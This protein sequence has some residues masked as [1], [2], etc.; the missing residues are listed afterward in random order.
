MLLC[1][2]ACT[3]AEQFVAGQAGQQMSLEAS[4]QSFLPQPG[5][6]TQV[7]DMA[8]DGALSILW[9]V[10]DSIGVFGIPDAN[11][12]FV[13]TAGEAGM[14]ATFTGPTVSSPGYAYYP[15]S[16]AATSRTAIPVSIPS[17]QVYDGVQ[18]IARNDIKA[19][20]VVRSGDT[21]TLNF[22]QMAALVRFEFDLTGVSTLAADELLQDVTIHQTETSV[23][24]AGEFTYDLTNLEA[25]LTPGDYQMDGITLTFADPLPVSQKVVAYAV[26]APGQHAGNEWSCVFATDKHIVTFTTTALCDFEAGKYYTVPLTFEVLQNNDATYEEIPEVDPEEETANCYIV[27]EPGTYSFNATVIGNGE[28]GIIKGAGFH[29]EDPYINPQSA[30]VLWSDRKDFVTDVQLR[31]GRVYYTIPE[32]I[33]SSF[34]GTI[35]GNAVIAVYSEPNCQGDILWSWHIWGTK[36]EP[37][38]ETYTNQAGATFQVMDRDL[39]VSEVGRTDDVM[40]YQWGRKDPFPCQDIQVRSFYLDGTTLE[41]MSNLKGYNYR[42][43]TDVATIADAVKNPMYL[44]GGTKATVWPW[45]AEPNLYLWG[46]ANRV[47]PETLTDIATAGAGWNQ[48]KTIYDPSPVGYRVAN[49]FTF[50]GF[51]DMPSGTTGDVEDA[52]NGFNIALQR[53]D[54]INFVEDNTDEPSNEWAFMRYPGD[55]QGSIYPALNPIDGFD[56]KEESNVSA[57]YWWSAEAYIDATDNRARACYLET[58]DYKTSAGSSNKTGNTIDTY[59]RTGLLR[60][61]CPVRCVRE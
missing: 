1:A 5:T 34:D 13:N 24:M 20:E 36:G 39:G 31:N 12:P 53:L 16:A 33:A 32:A 59:A 17:E 21:Y 8:G 46:D 37:Q 56:G 43:T 58:D 28:E 4:S 48:Q 35:Q 23:P 50:S 57:G 14:S 54:Y 42:M 30:K 6:R 49:I 61:A 7:G 10:G 45:L 25:G 29:T 15:Y 11:V 2:A 3:D 26:V 47:L 9:S 18:S 40:L 41:K 38:D 55:T 60:L 44:I 22:H 27:T 51:T 19:A 52:D